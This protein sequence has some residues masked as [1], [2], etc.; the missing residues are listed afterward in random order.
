MEHVY[1]IAMVLVYTLS[2][3]VVQY[4]YCLGLCIKFLLVS[5]KYVVSVCMCACVY[6]AKIKLAYVGRDVYYYV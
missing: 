2:Y 6:N 4:I 5:V 1:Y 3:L